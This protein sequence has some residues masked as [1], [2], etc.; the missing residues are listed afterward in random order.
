MDYLNHYEELIN[1]AKSRNLNK[2]NSHYYVEKHH[3]IPKC[4]GGHNRKWNVVYLT[5]KEHFIAHLLLYREFPDDRGLFLGFHIMAH[6]KN[7][8]H[9]RIRINSKH[10]EGLKEKMK[11]I[12]SLYKNTYK[13]SESSKRRMSEAKKGKN[14][15]N[16]GKSK[17]Q[18]N[19]F[20]GQ[21]HSEEAKKK[22]GIKINLFDNNG[23]L[24]EKFNKQKELEL[25]FNCSRKTVI[26]MVENG[27][28]HLDNQFYGCIL[29]K[30]KN[31][32]EKR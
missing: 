17:E 18:L 16:F 19:T 14:N 12:N 10:F 1:K 27:Y 30:I 11:F 8:D 24:I 3:I 26:K 7:E 13:M 4:I 32:G 21:K 20:G 5:A 23:N 31:K 9:E 2:T 6:A 25:Y 29:K 28:I 15:P 22:M